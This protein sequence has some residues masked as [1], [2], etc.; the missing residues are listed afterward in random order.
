MDAR[1]IDAVKEAAAAKQWEKTRQWVSLVDELAGG[2]SQLAAEEI[3]DLLAALGR[4]IGEL[5]AALQLKTRRR[6]WANDIAKA[7]EASRARGAIQNQIAATEAERDAAALRFR[8]RLQE[9]NAEQ[10]RLSGIAS[11]GMTAAQQLRGT[12]PTELLAAIDGARQDRRSLLEQ[13]DRFDARLKNLLKD[14]AAVR[15]RAE[16]KR[17][18]GGY[19]DGKA[20]SRE[21]LR[22][23]AQE[24]DGQAELLRAQ[25]QPFVERAAELDDLATELEARLLEP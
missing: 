5:D 21:S 9:L 16:A 11:K 1:M 18:E 4:D 12:A 7:E 22:A 3:A 20:I 14:A 6:Q 24:L 10:Q 8:Q 17:F 25:R 13:I 2:E 15:Q 19:R 23:E